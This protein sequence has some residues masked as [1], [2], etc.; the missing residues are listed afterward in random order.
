MEGKYDLP[1]VSNESD[2]EEWEVRTEF[3]EDEQNLRTMLDQMV[4]T[5]AA[6][7]L[8]QAINTDFVE[9]IKNK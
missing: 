8:K 3:G 1:E 9:A 6:K 7:A 2:W 5:L 4:R